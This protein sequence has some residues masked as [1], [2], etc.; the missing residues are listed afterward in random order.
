MACQSVALHPRFICAYDP[1]CSS[2]VLILSI[3]R[4]QSGLRPVSASKT[5]SV[6]VADQ[7]VSG[8]DDLQRLLAD[9]PIGLPMPIAV[10]LAPN[11]ANLRPNMLTME[12]HEV[13]L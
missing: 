2:G 5:S 9:Q 10:I 6:S 3:R 1:A 12:P 13:V 7:P 4:K 8:V 11:D